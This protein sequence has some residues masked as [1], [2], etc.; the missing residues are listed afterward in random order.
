MLKHFLLAAGV[1]AL[2][3]ALPATAQ[4]AGANQCKA[5]AGAADAGT[6]NVRTAREKGSSSA[7]GRRGGVRVA[8]G[9]V[10]GDGATGVPVKKAILHVRKSGGDAAEAARMKC[11]NNLKQLGTAAH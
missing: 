11:Q 5:S 1:C 6:D 9:D 8:V 4:D 7:T 3:A 2:T 10:N